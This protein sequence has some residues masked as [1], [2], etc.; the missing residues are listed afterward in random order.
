M[1]RSW[2]L[3]ERRLG[4]GEL[5]AG[6]LLP[7]PAVLLPLWFGLGLGCALAQTPAGGLRRSARRADRP[8]LYAAQFALLAAS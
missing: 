3:R 2:I 7:G 8:H 1:G 4:S 5:L 6:I